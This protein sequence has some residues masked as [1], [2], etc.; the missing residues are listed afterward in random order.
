MVSVELCSYLYKDF[1]GELMKLFRLLQLVRCRW[2]CSH[3]TSSSLQIFRLRN[4]QSLRLET[5]R[6]RNWPRSSSACHASAA[7]QPR[8][9]P[10]ARPCL[11]ASAS[12]AKSQTSRSGSAHSFPRPATARPV[13]CSTFS[14]TFFLLYDRDPANYTFWPSRFQ[15]DI[16]KSDKLREF[17][18]RIGSMH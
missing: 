7:R 10:S 1:A 14:L 4:T 5:T 16:H 8:R 17:Q 2:T 6:E 15:L 11:A 18:I 3:H 13:Q 12:T 9:H